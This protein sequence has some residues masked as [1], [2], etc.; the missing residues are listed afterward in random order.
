MEHFDMTLNDKAK[1]GQ[2]HCGKVILIGSRLLVATVFLGIFCPASAFGQADYS[3]MWVDDSNPDAAY[4]VGAGVTEDD[5]TNGGGDAIGVETTITS[6]NGRTQ[7]GS[8]DG[9]TDARVEV[10]LPW[11]WNDLGEYFVQTRHQPL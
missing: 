3:D 10:T 2:P 5:Y 11:D 4:I 9:D 7:S 6:P 8:A 1:F